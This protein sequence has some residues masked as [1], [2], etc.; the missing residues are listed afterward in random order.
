MKKTIPTGEKPEAIPGNPNPAMEMNDFMDDRVILYGHPGLC[1][2]SEELLSSDGFQLVLK[3]FLKKV[4]AQDSPILRCLQP[5]RSGADYDTVKLASF[6]KELLGR[7][8]GETSC[9][10]MDPVVL[11]D[12]VEELYSYWRRRERFV[13]FDRDVQDGGIDLKEYHPIFIQANEEFKMLV[14]GTYRHIAAHV[15]GDWFKVYRQIPA[16]VGVGLLAEK[17][18]WKFPGEAYHKLKNIPFIRLSLIYPPLIYYTKVNKR[19]GKFNPLSKNPM[20]QV[21]LDSS[22]WLCFPAKIG[23]LLVFIYFNKDFLSHAAGLSNLFELASAQEIANRPPD[24]IMLFGV[25]PALMDNQLVGYY[26]DQANDVLVGAVAYQM[27]DVDYFGY[28]KKTALTIHNLIMIRRGNLPIHGAMAKIDLK[29]GKTANVVIVGDSGAGK[30]ESLEAFRVLADKY[31]RQ[32]TVIFDDMGSLS[33]GPDG[34]VVGRGTEI[35][36]FV[37][38]DDL[39]PGYAYTEIDRSVFMNPH[40]GNARLVMPIT[41]YRHVVAG[42]PVDIFLYANN[43]D[44]VADDNPALQITADAAEANK[45]FSD[46]ARLAKGTTD[47]KGLVHTYFANPFGAPQKRKEH[48]VLADRFIGTL[49]KDGKKVGQLRTRLGIAGYETKGPEEAAQALFQFITQ[50]L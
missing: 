29:S 25:D 1:R 44:D 43:Y 5:F 24:G 46:G 10:D 9:A 34:K 18:Q 48:E 22:R 6:L 42:Y 33:M 31:I 41:E 47:E 13:I 7:P 17:I 8:I 39:H 38:L 50:N 26:E 15:S 40:L 23:E 21:K 28:F 45:V 35:G 14:L 19:K 32:L 20:D 3:H 49:M 30:S 11:K 27:P 2:T 36:A 12:L 4:T 16:G 37:R